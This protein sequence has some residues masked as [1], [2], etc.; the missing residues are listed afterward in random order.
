MIPVMIE[1]IDNG[2]RERVIRETERYISMAENLYRRQFPRIP[3]H[4]DLSGSSA[5]M[6]KIKGSDSRI[7]Y[8]PWLFAKYFE[9]NLSGTVPHEVA[10]YIVHCL[11]GLHRV[12]PHGP[13]WRAVMADF[14][15]DASVTG[16]FD[17]TG[18]PTRQHRR[19][20]Y[21]CDCREHQVT[22]RRHNLVSGGKARYACRL[23]NGELVYAGERDDRP[24]GQSA[25]GDG[26]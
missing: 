12:R 19:F 8:N 2:A 3:V 9:E 6:F 13:E 26:C 22:T 18:I 4:F 17:L 24:A 21:R 7:R 10:H 11:Y 1:P 15:A 23:C 5:G 16:D 25:W 20:R 14:G